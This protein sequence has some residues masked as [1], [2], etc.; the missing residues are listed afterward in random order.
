MAII[1]SVAANTVYIK[2]IIPA[3]TINDINQPNNNINL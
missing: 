2:R 3:G 1:Y